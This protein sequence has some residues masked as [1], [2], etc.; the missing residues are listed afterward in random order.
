MK[1]AWPPKTD[2]VAGCWLPGRIDC[3]DPSPEVDQHGSRQKS[4][5]AGNEPARQES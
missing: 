4:E 1:E 3:A 2:P 5:N